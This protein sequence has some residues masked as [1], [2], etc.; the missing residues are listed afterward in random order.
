MDKQLIADVMNE[1]GSDKSIPHHYEIGYEQLLDRTVNNLMEIGIANAYRERSSIWGWS[2]LFPEAFI[3]GI[4]VVPEKMIN[5]G[6]ILTFIADQSDV[7]ALKNIIN[8]LGGKKMD[9]IID[10]GSHWFKDSSVSFNLLFD[11]LLSPGGIYIIEDIQKS[12]DKRNS[13]MPN[14]QTINDWTKLLNSRNLDFGTID[15]VPEKEDDS[16]LLFVKKMI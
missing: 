7:A 6:K 14:Q 4:D 5:H 16:L 3:Y 15:C 8:L 11:E 9:V 2:Q 1:V 13:I 10:D 12:E